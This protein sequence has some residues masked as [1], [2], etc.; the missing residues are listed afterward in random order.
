M[1]SPVRWAGS[2]KALLPV[3]REYW[4][5]SFSRYIEPFCGSAC[6]F[7]DLEPKKALLGDINSELIHSY[8][9]LSTDPE[10]VIGALKKQRKSKANYYRLRAQ[11]PSRLSTID[12]AARFF[13]LNR[14]AFN[15]IYRTNRA[16]VFNVPYGDPKSSIKFD[17][18][19]LRSAATLLERAKLLNSDF[20]SVLD[21]AKAGDF[22][23]LDPPYAVSARRVFSEYH[24]DSFSQVDLKRLRSMLA[25]LNRKNVGFV[26]SYADSAEG[27]ALSKGWSPRRVLTRRHIA[28]FADARRSAFEILASNL[29]AH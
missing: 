5:T 6:L 9:A 3:L 18:G 27:R 14:F 29:E 2:K 1:K 4:E 26:V 28:G 7:F 17:N 23:Y 25:E 13:F 15:A 8:R 21:R 20:E 11:D 10:R 19:V 24:P 22:V 12:R 16:G